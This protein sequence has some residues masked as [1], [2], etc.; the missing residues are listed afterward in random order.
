MKSSFFSWF[1]IN[2]LI[3]MYL[4]LFH[5]KYPMSRAC[6]R[7]CRVPVPTC[8]SSPAPA[9]P[10]WCSRV[11]PSR[12]SSS[13]TRSAAWGPCWWTPAWR[14]GRRPPGRSGEPGLR[15]GRCQYL[16]VNILSCRRATTKGKQ[17]CSLIFITLFLSQVR[18]DSTL[19]SVVCCL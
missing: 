5:C 15:A 19:I 9:S 1:L 2:S 7:S 14:S 8:G 17:V 6:L 10:G 4:L 18:N 16:H 11:R 13:G 3:R 12:C